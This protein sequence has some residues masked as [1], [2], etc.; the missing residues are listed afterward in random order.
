MDDAQIQISAA[1]ADQFREAGYFAFQGAIAPEQ[2]QALQQES[3]GLLGALDEEMEQSGGTAGVNRG[4]RRYFVGGPHRQSPIMSAFAFGELM[5]RICRAL[6]GDSA[7]LWRDLLVAKRD[8]GTPRLAW[9]QESG[10]VAGDHA[11]FVNCLCVLDDIDRKSGAFY[12]LPLDRAAELGRVD[13]LSESEVG[14]AGDETGVR[15]DMPAGSVAVFSSMVFHRVGANTTGNLRRTYLL[16]YSA[17]P[18]PGAGGDEIN[19]YALPFLVDGERQAPPP[20]DQPV[21]AESE[22]D[23]DEDKE[24]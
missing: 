4:D 1:K 19:G 21:A 23:P 17:A 13:H 24:A 5:A 16:Q 7:F 22:D 3:D 14:Y 11:P 6:L 8:E 9:H 10:Y 18:L 2:L 12:L 15:L 20:L